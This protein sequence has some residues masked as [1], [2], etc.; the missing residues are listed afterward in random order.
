MEDPRTQRQRLKG[1]PFNK[2]IPNI[3]T[4]LALCAGMTGIRFAVLERWEHAVLAILVAAILDALDG[5]VA[6]ILKGTSKFGAELDSLADIVNFGVA[7]AMMLFLWTMKDAG[8]IGWVLS[9]L[10]TVC[11]VLRLARFNTD[12]DEP[13]M[14]RWASNF[15]TGVP[16]P[17]AAG[18]VLLP[19]MLSF[20][21][22]DGFFREPVVVAV[23]LVVVSGLMVSRFPTFAFKKFKVAHRWVLPTML[24]VG[25]FAASLASM[26][27]V[28]ISV[29]LI[30]YMA[31]FPISIRSFRSLKRQ[32]EETQS[33][34]AA[35]NPPQ[36]PPG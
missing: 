14:P 15:F 32:T 10:F 4:L 16:A 36:P 5:R 31:S 33:D 9:L 6:R 8:G 2:M 7:P 29:I 35:A 3:L 26:T 18:L 25:L 24:F 20:Q 34:P 12:L 17:M 1:L 22:G 11:C 21:V 19:M 23:F 27:W 28:T 13:D 30:A